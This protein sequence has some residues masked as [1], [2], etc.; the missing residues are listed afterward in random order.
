VLGVLLLAAC[1]GGGGADPDPG[2]GPTPET[3]VTLSGTV[4]DAAGLPVGGAEVLLGQNPA[5]AGA[6]GGFSYPNLLPG[7]YTISLQDQA[8]SFDCRQIDLS[9][10]TSTVSFTL[11]AADD[12]LRAVGVAPPLNASGA[13]LSAAFTLTF[14]AELDP[15]SVAADDFTI[16][17]DVGQLTVAVDGALV[18]LTPVL[19]LPTDQQILIELT[20]DVEDL[21]GGS[22]SQ[23]V[24]WRLRTSA[25]DV[26]P[27]QFIGSVPADGATGHAPNAAVRL[28]FNETLGAVDEGVIATVVPEAELQLRVSGRYLLVGAAGGWEL[29]TGYQLSVSGVVDAAGSRSEELIELSFTTGDQIAPQSHI[30]PEWNR[31]SGLIVFAADAGGAW[32]IFSVLPDGSELTQLTALPGDEQSP[33][34]SAD[35][36]L[37]AFQYRDGG[38]WS[39]WVQALEQLAEPVQITPDD[40]SDTAPQFSRTISNRLIFVSDRAEPRRLIMVNADGSDPVDQDSDFGLV[41]WQPALHPLLDTQM[42]LAAGSAGS[43]DIWRK[44]VSAVD[45]TAININ[46]TSAML[47]DEHS[48]DWGPDAGY[49]VFLSDFAGVDNLWYAEATGEFERQVTTFAEPVLGVSV[50]PVSG[51]GR[52]VVSVSDGEGGSDLAVVD[53]VSGEVERYLTGEGGD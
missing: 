6:D 39:I 8:G 23:P 33:T 52:A 41:S 12:G 27:P 38:R 2:P 53:L 36:Q 16:T 34:L 25:A 45:G 5:T 3:R 40:Y 26:Y 20:G 50:S 11:P 9:A 29:L 28:E 19:Q 14:S 24:R 35:G 7:Q 32:D 42:L 51:E 49:I 10:A 48:P 47:S 22:L 43:R 31:V 17:P 21:G 13:P 30:D 18:T 44:T 37:L 1:G 15:A 4:R 46:M